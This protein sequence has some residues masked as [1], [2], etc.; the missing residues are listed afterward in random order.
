MTVDQVREL[1]RIQITNNLTATNAHRISLEQTLVPPQKIL[2][3]ARLVKG[4]RMKDEELGVWLVGQ[5][6]SSDGYRIIMR[7]DGLQFGLASSRF[8]TD[9][10][11]VLVGW[12][13]DL[14][15]AFLNM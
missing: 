14:V 10:H 5:E 8:P 11:L 1:I 3:I 12:Y 4:A 15:S 9:R 7:D 2:V 6:R 13:G